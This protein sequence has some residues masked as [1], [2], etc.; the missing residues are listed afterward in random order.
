MISG[1]SYD[2]KAADIW[3]AGIILY[4]MLVGRLPFEDSNTSQL[5][6]KITN[7]QYLIPS[8]VSDPAR[9]LIKALLQVDPSRRITIEGVRSSRWY[10]GLI[11]VDRLCDRPRALQFLSGEGCEVPSCSRCKSWVCERASGIPIDEQVLAKMTNYEFPLDYVIKCLKLNKHNHATTTYHLLVESRSRS[12]AKPDESR[13]I[14]IDPTKP[15]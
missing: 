5:Y 11:F 4:A 10:Q 1:L 7:G 12:L 8:Q 15:R 14:T 9:S 3:S 2:P 13:K 6:R